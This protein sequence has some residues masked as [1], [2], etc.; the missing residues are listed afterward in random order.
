MI[1]YKKSI[2]N[3]MEEIDKEIE[4]LEELLSDDNPYAKEYFEEKPSF[5][6]WLIDQINEKKVIR[7]QKVIQDIIES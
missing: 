6:D 1:E 3:I 2:N 7:R 5:K 4:R